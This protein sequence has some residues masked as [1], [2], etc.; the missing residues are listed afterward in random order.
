MS[1]QKDMHSLNPDQLDSVSGGTVTLGVY[2]SGFAYKQE[3]L[4]FFRS[5]VG[6]AVYSRAMNSE[7][8]HAHHYAVA[9]AFLSKSDWEKFCW[10]EQFGSLD[11]FP[12]D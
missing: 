8:G 4:E 5:C 11:G 7:A 6:D 1:A 10:I 9:R 2:K 12:E 3:S